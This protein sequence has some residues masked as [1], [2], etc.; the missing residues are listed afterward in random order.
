MDNSFEVLLNKSYTYTDSNL[1]NILKTNFSEEPLI[2][3]I[4]GKKSNLYC[5]FDYEKSISEKKFIDFKILGAN[6]FR[7]VIFFIF[8]FRLTLF[9]R[10]IK[11]KCKPQKET[12][13]KR[14]VLV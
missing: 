5:L 11:P 2:K 4:I 3:D 9:S 6:V 1:L 14:I 8:P 10:R 7:L 12:N 13:N